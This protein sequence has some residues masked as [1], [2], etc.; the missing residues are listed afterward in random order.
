MGM[1]LAGGVSPY[2]LLRVADTVGGG[3]RFLLLV[4]L[5]F[6]VLLVVLVGFVG[7]MSAGHI[8]VRTFC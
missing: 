7:N 3:C 1:R 2:W 5:I 6:L 8:N 4:L